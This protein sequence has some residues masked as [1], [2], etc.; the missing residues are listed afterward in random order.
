MKPA[1]AGIEEMIYEWAG[2]DL[3]HMV[4][5]ERAIMQIFIDGC[6]PW[7]KYFLDHMIK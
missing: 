7:R 1:F 5:A 6:G 4:Q 3:M 2:H